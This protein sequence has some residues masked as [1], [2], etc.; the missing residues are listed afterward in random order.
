MPL[1]F[2]SASSVRS[3]TR[4]GG[5]TLIEVLVSVVILAIGLLGLAG[6]QAAGLKL[7]HDSFLRS[8][9][10]LAA[11]DMADRIRANR[12]FKANYAVA[13]GDGASAHGGFAK[14]DVDDW[15][16]ML[17]QELP[18]GDGSVAIA[19]GDRF[20]ITIEWKDTRNN[21]SAIADKTFTLVT[22]I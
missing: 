3:G 1:N 8:K 22:D 9:A 15:L 6:M 20:T 7:N 13:M 11:Y 19:A 14:E 4:Q 2:V 10:T 5:F 16:A 18:L 12:D 21:E 17:A